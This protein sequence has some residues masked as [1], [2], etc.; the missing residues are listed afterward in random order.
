[1]FAEIIFESGTR[2]VG[3][4]ESEEEA[5]S[6]AASQHSR[7]TG[8]PGGPTG[9]SAERVVAIHLYDSHPGDLPEPSA[10]V[11]KEELSKIDVEQGVM[12]TAAV[13][14]EL[15]SPLVETPVEGESMYKME[16]TKILTEGW[17]EE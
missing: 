1:M 3:E 8:A 7:A 17:E 6:A 12:E 11:L 15:A 14:R 16:A 2:S 5:L 4:Y 13:V 9:H 10:E